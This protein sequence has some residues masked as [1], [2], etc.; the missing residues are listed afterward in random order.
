MLLSVL[1]VDGQGSCAPCLTTYILQAVQVVYYHEIRSGKQHCQAQAFLVMSQ[2]TEFWLLIGLTL[3]S[4]SLYSL[5]SLISPAVQL[6][7]L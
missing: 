7:F 1:A 4:R 3:F 2:N 6:E 5:L